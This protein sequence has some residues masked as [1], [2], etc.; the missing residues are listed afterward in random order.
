M[1][2]Q[3]LPRDASLASPGPLSLQGKSEIWMFMSRLAPTW[4]RGASA[5]AAGAVEDCQQGV[6][7]LGVLRT[8]TPGLG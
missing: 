6:E 1:F 2:F 3:P 4:G 5:R 8:L 7:G